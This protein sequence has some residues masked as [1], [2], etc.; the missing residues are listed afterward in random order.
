MASASEATSCYFVA[1]LGNLDP[2]IVERLERWAAASCVDYASRRA[3]DGSVALYAA[4]A[5]AKTA[6]QYQSLLRTLSSHW[7]MPFGK[8]E[9]GWV[10]LLTEAEYRGNVEGATARKDCA[11]SDLVEVATPSECAAPCAHDVCQASVV[12]APKL[13]EVDVGVILFSLGEGFDARAR[14]GYERLLA[15]RCAV[16]AA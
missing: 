13:P 10:T 16:C 9:R 11:G 15:E 1:N 14:A 4:K 7:S 5:A 8:L 6:R 3:E 2:A 12:A